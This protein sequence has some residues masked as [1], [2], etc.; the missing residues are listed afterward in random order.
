MP[1]LSLKCSL[2]EY[3]ISISVSPNLHSPWVCSFT[4][5]PAPDTP[6]IA[7]KSCAAGTI[8]DFAASLTNFGG[9]ALSALSSISPIRLGIIAVVIKIYRKC[10]SLFALLCEIDFKAVD[11]IYRGNCLLNIGELILAFRNYNKARQ[12]FSIPRRLRRLFL[13]P[14]IIT[15]I[16]L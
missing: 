12:C 8:F 1:V 13:F 7:N 15:S 10:A 16:F 5:F 14:N 6:C 11:V 4:E 2:F 3:K 9:S